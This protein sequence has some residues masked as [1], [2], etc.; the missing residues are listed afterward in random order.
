MWKG[1]GESTVMALRIWRPFVTEIVTAVLRL[2]TEAGRNPFEPLEGWYWQVADSIECSMGCLIE[3]LHVIGSLR[4]THIHKH[5][6]TYIRTYVRT[7]IYYN[8]CVAHLIGSIDLGSL[9]LYE[10]CGTRL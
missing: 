9:A 4:Y 3:C 8:I 10:S 5:M 7:H 1:K 6:Y 2:E